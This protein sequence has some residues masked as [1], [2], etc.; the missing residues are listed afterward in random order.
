MYN[1]GVYI[2]FPSSY[3]KLSNLRIQ[4][5]LLALTRLNASYLLRMRAISSRSIYNIQVHL[6]LNDS[7]K[8]MQQ[9]PRQF[10]NLVLAYPAIFCFH[11]GSLDV[12]AMLLHHTPL[13]ENFHGLLSMSSCTVCP[14]F[15]ISSSFSQ[16]AS[17]TGWFF[18][19]TRY[20]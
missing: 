11:A 19:L 13:L 16:L 2:H 20:S 17:S 1:E 7:F 4:F 12:L 5:Y 10:Q 8:I 6:I 18:H 14:C 9:L 3:L 15:K